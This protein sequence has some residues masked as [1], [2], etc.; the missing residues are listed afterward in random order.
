MSL[1]AETIERMTP[2]EVPS[3]VPT[4]ADWGDAFD[5]YLASGNA[6]GRRLAAVGGQPRTAR[7]IG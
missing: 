1:L 5:A 4:V 6:R 3:G 2:D 7:D